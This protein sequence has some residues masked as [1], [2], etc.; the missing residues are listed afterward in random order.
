M[1]P[2][3]REDPDL[4]NPSRRR[5]IAAGSGRPVVEVNRMIK[6]FNQSKQ[7]MNQMSKGNMKGLDGL[8]G[9]GVSGK[10]GKWP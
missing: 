7:M 9:G 2:K 10:L 6:Q 4:L 3:E 8:M 5:R 1:T